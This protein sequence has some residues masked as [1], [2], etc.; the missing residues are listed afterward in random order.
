[1]IPHQELTVAALGD[2]ELTLTRGFAAPRTL[3]FQAHTQPELLQRWLGV[4]AGWL[5]AVCEIDLRVGGLY[6]YV[7]R[8]ATKGLEMGL[9]GKYLE[10]SAPERLVCTELFDNPWYPGDA[11]VTT[12]FVEEDGQTAL[13]M[14]VRYATAEARD[15]ALQSGMATGVGESYDKLAEI[16]ECGP[17]AT[18]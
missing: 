8:H 6:R 4:R 11:V 13:T 9:G 1:M 2:R 16:L 3:V 14:T 15:M 18:R 17:P 12:V 7:W 5:L 10:I